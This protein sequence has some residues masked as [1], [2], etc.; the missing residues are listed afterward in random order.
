MG[1]RSIYK[2]TIDEV[3]TQ[4]LTLPA[5]SKILSVIN[6]RDVIRIYAMVDP[7]TER[8]EKYSIEIYGT[9]HTIRHD[10]TYKFLGTVVLYDGEIV[11][12]VFYKKL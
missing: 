2:Y 1:R 9:G 6:Q 8:T 4:T 11:F 12:H 10:D 7:R 5:G 3:G